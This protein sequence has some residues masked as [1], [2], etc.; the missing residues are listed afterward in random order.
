MRF[1][2]MLAAGLAASALCSGARAAP[3][4]LEAYGRLPAID[5]MTIS[6]DGDRFAFVGWTGQERKLFVATV[7]G[8]FLIQSPLGQIKARG[9][10]WAGDDHLLVTTSTTADLRS[11]YF[12]SKYEL[13]SVVQIDVANSK[14]FTVFKDAT[15][16]V[17]SVVVGE[18][19]TSGS[20]GK[21]QG[22]FG[23]IGLKR[24]VSQQFEFDHGWP[25]LYSVDLDT[26]HT[27]LVVRGGPG[28]GGWTVAP[29]G[30]VVAHEDY[31]DHTGHWR[32]VSGALA[33]RT[34]VERTS[35]IGAI[36]LAG[37]GRTPDT[38][39][40]IDN[41]G[42]R[43]TVDEVSMKDGSAQRLY[44]DIGVD[45]YLHDPSTHL[46]L[47]A[48]EDD[49]VGAVFFDPKLTERYAK[50]QR[51]FPGL[52]AHLVSFSHGMNQVIVATEGAGDPGT[53]WLVDLG[54]MKA[55][56]IGDAYPE[57]K[58]A[59]VG[60]VS[61]I[62]YKA[63]DGLQMDGVLTLPPGKPAKNLPLVVMPHGGPIDWWDTPGFDSWAQAFASRGYAV[64]QPNYRGSGGHGVAFRQAGFGEWGGKMLSDIRDGM[65]A[66][67]AQGI[68]NPRRACIV[69]ASYGGYAALAGVT[70]QHG[71]YRCAVAVSAPA[72]MSSFFTREQE[73]HGW[74]TDRYMKAA[75]GMDKQG[76]QVLRAISPT[77]YADKADAPVL[78][79]QGLDDTVVPIEQSREMQAALKRAGKDVQLIEIPGGDHWET[80][81]DARV[82]TVTNSVNFVLKNNPPD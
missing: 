16:I 53:Y 48:L 69:G 63:A 1:W 82:A 2:S 33:G 74:S 75:T 62:Q 18:Y 8:K 58:P 11:I 46:L 44:D 35:P 17:P 51:A 34:V 77:T 57:I 22:Y 47:G 37:L 28:I 24:G 7:T 79:I 32:L 10:A 31:D 43:S 78:L 6:P 49:G 66:L 59:D 76:V 40:V 73:H 80:H 29:D 9:V 45:R 55:N 41:T 60:P 27:N 4:P 23:G 61:V 42:D 54:A 14:G 13:D 67:A 5:L 19:G 71:L 56:P 38:V 39:L 36:A 64:F 21:W 68:I 72:D 81:E 52:R 30:T 15:E 65:A 25:D 20:G 26:G 12:D 50:I 3:P 70:L